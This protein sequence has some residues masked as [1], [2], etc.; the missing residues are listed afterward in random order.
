MF[1]ETSAVVVVVE[2]DVVAVELLGEA[3]MAEGFKVALVLKHWIGCS[4]CKHNNYWINAG[5]P[6][7]S[8]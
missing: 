6:T 1:V 4:T 3:V 7:S 8:T 2:V 5:K